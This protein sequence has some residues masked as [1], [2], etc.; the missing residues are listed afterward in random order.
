M[1]SRWEVRSGKACEPSSV[2]GLSP[3]SP[4]TTGGKSLGRTPVRSGS[5]GRSVEDSQE[6]VRLEAGRLGRR[7]QHSARG[8]Q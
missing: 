8:K 7:L 2:G 4:G 5:Q 6:G 3:R 1:G